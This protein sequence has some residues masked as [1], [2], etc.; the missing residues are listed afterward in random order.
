MWSASFAGVGLSVFDA[1]SIHPLPDRFVRTIIGEHGIGLPVQDTGPTRQGLIA[2]E[3]QQ[4][5]EPQER[6]R[7]PLEPCHLFHEL[8]IVAC[9]EAI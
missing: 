7:M 6:T 8:S 1:V 2:I 4:G 5:V 3:T 9:I